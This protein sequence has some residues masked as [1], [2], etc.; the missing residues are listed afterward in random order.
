MFFPPI[1]YSLSA[2]KLFVVELKWFLCI[3]FNKGSTYSQCLKYDVNYTDI[4]WESGVG[5]NL[6]GNEST[7]TFCTDGWEYDV[8]QVS[9]S[10]VIDVGWNI[11]IL[12]LLSFFLVLKFNYFLQFD[13]VCSKSLYPTIG[14]SALNVGGLVGVLLFGYLND[15]LDYFCLNTITLLYNSLKILTG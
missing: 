12:I 8:E 7:V 14:L 6:T 9:S 1:S 11:M 3:L 13:L 2:L 4:V 5:S 15:R 10:I